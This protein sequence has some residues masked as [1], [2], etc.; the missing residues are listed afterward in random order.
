MLFEKSPYKNVIVTGL[1][2]DEHGRKMGKSEGNAVSPMDAL[3]KHGADAVRWFMYVNSAPWLN[4]RYSDETVIEGARRFMGTLWNTYAFYVLYAEIDQFNPYEHQT[5]DLSVMDKWLLSRLN[6]LIQKVDAALEAFEVTEPARL[7]D[8]FVD[9]LSNWYLRR[10]RERYWGS[11]MTQDKIN[12]YKTLHH[13]LVTVAKLSA[14]FVPFISEQLY[15]NLVAR[16]DNNAP[17]SVHLCDFPVAETRFIDPE[18]EAQMANTIEIVTQGRAARNAGNVK[19]RQPLAE[20]LVALASADKTPDASL[21]EVI[22]EELNVKAVNFIADASEYIGYV[23][24]PQLRTLGPR[25]GKLL[26]KI[27]PV[28]NLNPDQTMQ[29]LKEGL[30]RASI[31]GIEVE[32]TMDDVL[33]ET[34]QKEGFAT[35]SDKGVTVVLNT[36][37]TPALIEEG[38]LRELVSKWQNMRRDAGFDV[39][40]R[41]TAGYSH[42]AVL[43]DVIANHHAAIAAEL[44]ADELSMSPAPAGARRARWPG[45]AGISSP[46]GMASPRPAGPGGVSRRGCRR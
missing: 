35:A 17:I 15:Q 36:I 25:Y 2:L 32:L 4:F 46:G 10:S 20:M 26:P 30:W 31:D 37:L 28:L 3:T 22:R 42:N 29:H 41:I 40:D 38:N 5:K 8:Q 24:K 7:L 43:S 9:D 11:D 23:F 18:L 39:T 12:A 21:Q 14:P 45:Y 19:T 6:T 1:G 27:A 34:T 13:A 44:L 33:I 16:F